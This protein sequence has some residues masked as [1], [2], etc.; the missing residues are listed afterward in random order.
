M[1]INILGHDYKLLEEEGMFFNTGNY[2]LHSYPKLEIRYDPDMK[3]SVYKE[4]ILHEIIEAL[5][6]WLNL[7][8]DHHQLT[9]LSASLYGVINSNKELKEKL[10]TEEKC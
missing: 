2:G 1:T 4:A 7:K 3:V 10:F 8:L 5:D 6:Y 9:V